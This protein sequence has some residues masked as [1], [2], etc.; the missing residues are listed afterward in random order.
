LV[1]DSIEHIEVPAVRAWSYYSEKAARERCL[2]DN[3]GFLKGGGG[4]N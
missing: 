1:S 2:M 3:S 4:K